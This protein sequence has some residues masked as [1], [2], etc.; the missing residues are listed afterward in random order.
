MKNFGFADYDTVIYIGT[1]GK[2]NELCAAM[3]L[4]NLEQPG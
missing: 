3:G 4:T 2:M 1:N